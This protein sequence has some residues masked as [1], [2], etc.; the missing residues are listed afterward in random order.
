[1]IHDVAQRSS[2]QQQRTEPREGRLEKNGACSAR[3]GVKIN[4]L[5]ATDAAR[6]ADV[7]RVVSDPNSPASTLGGWSRDAVVTGSIALA[8]AG[9]GRLMTSRLS[10]PASSSRARLQCANPPAD[11]FTSLARPKGFEPS[12]DP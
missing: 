12:D 10:T 4:C 7:W 8:L 3:E 2:E 11:L 9:G 5:T 6:P 1:M